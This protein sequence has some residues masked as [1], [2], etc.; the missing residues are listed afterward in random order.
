MPP[1]RKP[2]RLDPEFPFD[3]VYRQQRSNRDEL[4]DHL[5]DLFELVYIHE[6]KGTFF[7]DHAFYDKSEGDL[8]LIPGNTIHRSFPDDNDPIVSTALFFAPY[9]LSGALPQESYSPLRC[10]E[11]ARKNKQFKIRLADGQQDKVRHLLAGIGRE[12]RDKQL[13]YRHAVYLLLQQLVLLLNRLPDQSG[14]EMAD[15]RIGPQ[16]LLDLLRAI[17]RDPA[18]AGGLSGLAA[19][20]YVTPSHFS[21]TFKSMTGMTVTQYMT[22][23]K[24]ALAK[25][26]LQSTDDSIESIAYACGFSTLSLFYQKFKELTTVTPR[27]FRNRLYR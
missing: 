11:L 7:I 17:D 22:V 24:I 8:F 9:L 10:F 15:S 21:R 4:P 5:H 13:G 18:A 12:M 14:T 3:I 2:F 25:E 6:G 16:W 19:Q 1:I 26:L 27:A 20:A 23:K